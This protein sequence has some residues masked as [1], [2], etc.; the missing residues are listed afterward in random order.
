MAITQLVCA[1]SIA[2]AH[3]CS[4][5]STRFFTFIMLLFWA[6]ALPAAGEDPAQDRQRTMPARCIEHVPC[7]MLAVK[8]DLVSTLSLI[9]NIGLELPLGCN[10][11]AGASWRGSWLE[12]CSKN[13]CWKCYGGAFALRWYPGLHTIYTRMQRYHIGIE[14]QAYTFDFSLGKLNGA[15]GVQA[16]QWNMGACMEYGYRFPITRNLYLDASLGLGALWGTYFEYTPMDTHFVWLATKRHCY[17]G[18][19]KLE[20]SLVYHIQKGGRHHVKGF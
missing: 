9:P 6:Q 14:M 7:T 4:A 10:F 13:L 1:P 5:M 2:Q 16:P 20:L 15:V 12:D 17:Y 18:P 11:S 3:I 8:T 19:T